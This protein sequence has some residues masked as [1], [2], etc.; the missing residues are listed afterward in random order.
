[1]FPAA[2]RPPHTRSA[3]SSATRLTERIR[4][5]LASLDVDD[6]RALAEA[7]TEIRR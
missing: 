5:R 6:V 4:A 2:S 3:R 7:G 1:V